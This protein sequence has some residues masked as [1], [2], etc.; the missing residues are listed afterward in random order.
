MSPDA[1]AATAAVDRP[2]AV[3]KRE[4][5]I[6]TESTVQGERSFV[7]KDPVALRYHRLKP[8]EMLVLEKL[9]GTTSLAKLKAALQA[10]YPLAEFG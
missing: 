10:K 5:L 1:M 6:V 4:D 7:V 2:L 9:D 3:R 8:A